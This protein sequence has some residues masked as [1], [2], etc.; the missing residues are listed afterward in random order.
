MKWKWRTSQRYLDKLD[1]IKTQEL[2]PKYRKVFLYWPTYVGID[3]VA[4]LEPALQ[5]C[6][7]AFVCKKKPHYHSRLSFNHVFIHYLPKEAVQVQELQ[8]I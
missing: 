3:T 8:S 4:W 1:R 5:S 7:L 6:C 2:F